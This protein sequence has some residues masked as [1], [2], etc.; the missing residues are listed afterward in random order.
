[1]KNI[2]FVSAAIVVCAIS[3]SHTAHMCTQ[4]QRVVEYIYAECGGEKKVRKIRQ[5]G[6]DYNSN[7]DSARKI[8]F[9]SHVEFFSSHL[10]H[11]W[12]EMLSSQSMG[13]KKM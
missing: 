13:C 3:S 6:G 7:M 10:S 5:R 9:F 2:H 12:V 8:L 4:R 11:S 1:M